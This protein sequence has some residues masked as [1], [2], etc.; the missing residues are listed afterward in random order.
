MRI[1]CL[2]VPDFPLAA[3]LR[4]EPELCGASVVVAD[5]PGAR[6]RIVACAP[7][8][9]RCGITTGV[10]AAQALAIANQLVV[11]AASA[12]AEQAAHAALADVA[13]SF[14][15]RVEDG[16]PGT[17]Y[18]DA[19][20]LQALYASEAALAQAMEQR[21]QGLGLQALVGIAGSKIAAEL[22][23][24]DGGGCTVVPPHEEWR[25]L[26]PLS[27]DRLAP[28]PALRETLRRWGVRTLGDL[29]ALPASAL[30]AR[31][32]PDAAALARR[33]RGEDAHPLAPRPL[34]LQFEESAELDWGVDALEPFLFV[35]RGL[36]DR[37]IARLEVRG[38]VC[39]DLRLSLGLAD[40]GRDERTVT[41]AAP[42][43]ARKPLLTLLRVHLESHPPRAPVEHIRLAAVPERLRAAQ[44]DLFRPH[45]PAPALLAATLARLNALCGD[46]VVGAPALVDTHRPESFDVQP[47]QVERLAATRERRAAEPTRSDVIAL[48]TVRPPIALE[49]F[50]RRDQPDYIRLADDSAPAGIG[51]TGRVVSIAGPWRLQAEWWRPDLLHRDYYDAH[52][53]DGGMYRLFFDRHVQR[54]FLDASYD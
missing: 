6:G 4:A 8:A 41:V 53:T 3:W 42:S 24:R 32:G 35:A 49:V 20:G 44:L 14:S 39:G 22:A 54:W 46:T 33:A 47:F 19:D 43:N 50:C 26:A 27:I 31:L 13:Y 17:V 45:G 28:P 11:R 48:R 18:V 52:L 51:C 5:A 1:A 16:T 25:L 9:T 34:P 37:L 7:G 30:A 21:A 10:T 38:L 36:L 40:R 29:A 2:Y 12:E 23:A 15:P